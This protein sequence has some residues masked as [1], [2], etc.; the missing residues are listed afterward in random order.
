MLLLLLFFFFFPNIYSDI[1]H[2]VHTYTH[3]HSSFVCVFESTF[4]VVVAIS[5]VIAHIEMN[6]MSFV[7]QN[8]TRASIRCVC[9]LF[10]LKREKWIY[11]IFIWLRVLWWWQTKIQSRF[12]LT[13]ISSILFSSSSMSDELKMREFNSKFTFEKTQAIENHGHRFHF[14]EL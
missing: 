6:Q 12:V 9:V 14:R 1:V 3:T 2:F 11:F 7:S 13:V 5:L 4:A 8:A 10:A